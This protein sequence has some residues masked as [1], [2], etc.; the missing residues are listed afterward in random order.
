MRNVLLAG[1]LLG[2]LAIP[3]VAWTDEGALVTIDNFKFGPGA[4]TVAKGTEVTWANRDDIPHSIVMIGASV[5]SKPL[6]TDQ[7]FVYKFDKAGTFSY[8]CGLH[9]QMHGTVTVK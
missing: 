8:I 7:T 5:R 4:L 6:D 9:P 3:F 1:L 2:G